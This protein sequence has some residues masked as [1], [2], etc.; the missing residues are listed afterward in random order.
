[1]SR[2]PDQLPP[3]ANSVEPTRAIP[4]TDTVPLTDTRESARAGLA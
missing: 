4:E 3:L 1:V 2:G